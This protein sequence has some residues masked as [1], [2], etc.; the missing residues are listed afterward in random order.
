M[1]SQVVFGYDIPEHQYIAKEALNVWE[2]VDP[3]IKNY[4][5]SS[6][7]SDEQIACKSEL[8]LE[9]G[10]S[11][12]DD[13]LTGA[14]EEDNFT[15][16]DFTTIPIFCAPQNCSG[17]EGLNGYF[18]HFWEP[19]D[20]FANGYNC[21]FV[22]GGY[23]KGLGKNTLEVLQALPL[24][25]LILPPGA[26]EYFDSAYRLAQ[27]YW[28]WKVIPYYTGKKPDSNTIPVDKGKTYYENELKLKK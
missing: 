18:E 16:V 3:E 13:V 17:Y 6:N 20:P 10:Y 8:E 7:P 25:S 26:A 22:G 11:T 1:K 24:S 19:D 2:G 28:D 4:V 14:A 12:G 23:N 27:Y 15:G 21:G 9:L 5:R